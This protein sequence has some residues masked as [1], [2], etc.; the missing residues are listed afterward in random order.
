MKSNTSFTTIGDELADLRHAPIAGDDYVPRTWSAASHD[1]AISGPPPSSDKS[2]EE[3]V[4]EIEE[5]DKPVKESL[6]QIGIPGAGK[7]LELLAKLVAKGVTIVVGIVAKQLNKMANDN[8]EKK[9]T[10][11]AI[12]DSIDAHNDRMRDPRERSVEQSAVDRMEHKER[13]GDHT[14]VA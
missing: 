7:G 12:R 2:R 8:A 13:V 14:Q 5:R 4:R 3:Q 9:K 11:K 1:L 10:E 6:L